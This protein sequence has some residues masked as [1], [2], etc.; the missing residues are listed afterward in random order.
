MLSSM[1]VFFGPTDKPAPI[2][3]AIFLS[4]L[5][6]RVYRFLLALAIRMVLFSPYSPLLLRCSYYEPFNDIRDDRLAEASQWLLFVVFFTAL[7]I[8]LDATEDNPSEKAQL[9]IILILLS[10]IPAVYMTTTLCLEFIDLIRAHK[11][12]E[13]SPVPEKDEDDQSEVDVLPSKSARVFTSDTEVEMISADFRGTDG[14]MGEK[15]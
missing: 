14:N 6:I 1:L 8:R 7:L 15:D 2:V 11:G 3:V 5:T 10:L 12:A 13:V 4:L 9:G